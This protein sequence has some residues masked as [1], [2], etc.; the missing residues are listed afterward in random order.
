MSIS[1]LKS[2]IIAR[3]DTSEFISNMHFVEKENQLISNKLDKEG[4]KSRNAAYDVLLDDLVTH[5]QKR[6]V[7]RVKRGNK[8]AKERIAYLYTYAF[9]NTKIPASRLDFKP[10]SS[11]DDL[12]FWAFENDDLCLGYFENDSK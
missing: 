5:A 1:P 8:L 6:L 12:I 3:T 4:A 10:Y 2:S 7:I 9:K 11:K